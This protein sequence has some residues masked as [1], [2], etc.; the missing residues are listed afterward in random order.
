MDKCK[1]CEQV[2]AKCI[3]T[4]VDK[5]FDENRHLM[6]DLA[7]QE[8]R[9]KPGARRCHGCMFF[10]CRCQSGLARRIKKL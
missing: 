4:A 6:D 8:A 9:E 3:C 2:G 5:F 1:N 7:E 10:E